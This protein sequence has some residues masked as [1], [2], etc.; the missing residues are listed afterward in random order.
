MTHILAYSF[1]EAGGESVSATVLALNDFVS[2]T[3]PGGLEFVDVDPNGTT[4]GGILTIQRAMTET[5]L[6]TYGLFWGSAG[7]CQKVDPVPFGVIGVP[8]SGGQQPDCSGITCGNILIDLG[9]TG[10]WSVSRGRYA[11][12]ERATITLDG[13]GVV[14]FDRF[15]T[16]SGR[17]QQSNSNSYN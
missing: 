11:N 12:N 9:Q 17:D 14:A 6:A 5:S 10:A 13:P 16:E 3:Q 4:V 2:A 7:A 8:Q 15:Q 1:S